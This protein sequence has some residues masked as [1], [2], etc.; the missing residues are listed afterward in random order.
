MPANALLEASIAP[1]QGNGASLRRE[2]CSSAAK[3]DAGIGLRC[4]ATAPP[5]RGQQYS[6]ARQQC[7]AGGHPYPA[8]GH[9]RAAARNDRTRGPGARPRRDTPGV[10]PGG[11]GSCG[12]LHARGGPGTKGGCARE[13]LPTAMFSRPAWW[14]SVGFIRIIDS[15]RR[16]RHRN[17][18]P[19]ARSTPGVPPQENRASA[20]SGGRLPRLGF[21]GGPSERPTSA[22]PQARRMYFFAGVD[23]ELRRHHRYAPPPESSRRAWPARCRGPRGYGH[24]AAPCPPADGRTHMVDAASAPP[25]RHVRTGLFEHLTSPAGSGGSLGRPVGCAGVMSQ[26]TLEYAERRSAN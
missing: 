1:L 12:A 11:M 9:L 15:P 26:E 14:Q 2:Q 5:L 7:S 20:R 25:E 24:A 10:F 4:K 21:S 18:S 8:A 17:S 16:A 22:C 23:H 19:S 3:R 13:R 6:A